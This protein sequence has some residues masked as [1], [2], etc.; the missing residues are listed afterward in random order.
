VWKALDRVT[1]LATNGDDVERKSARLS[2]F[3]HNTGKRTS[4]GYD[5]EGTLDLSLWALLSPVAIICSVLRHCWAR[6]TSGRTE[7]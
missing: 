6:R 1:R 2:R 3:G 4:P 7:S 5:P